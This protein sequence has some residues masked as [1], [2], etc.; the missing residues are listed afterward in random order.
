MNKRSS[1]LRILLHGFFLISANLFSVMVAFVIV[2]VALL[3]EEKIVQSS[4]ALVINIGIYWLVYKVMSRIQDDFMRIDNFSMFAI[5]LL[6]SLAL[7]PAIFYP[8]HYLTQGYWSSFDN[9]LATWP[10]QLIVN[11]LCLVMNY[12]LLR[13][14]KK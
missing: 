1:L 2:R 9:L 3:N 11:G 10:F 5:I 4:L 7:L 8:M 14:E 6:V 13:S 12:F